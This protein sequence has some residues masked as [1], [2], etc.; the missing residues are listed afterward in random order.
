MARLLYYG[1]S[2]DEVKSLQYWL[3]YVSATQRKS[4]L[5]TLDLSGEFEGYT[6]RRV[7]EFQWFKGMEVKDGVVGPKTRVAI[8]NAAGVS[9]RRDGTLPPVPG[10]T[11]GL[12]AEHRS[13]RW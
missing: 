6:F 5:A 2:G 9:L 11:D 8:A 1:C 3:N 4:Y 7:L 13:Y 12:E 10:S